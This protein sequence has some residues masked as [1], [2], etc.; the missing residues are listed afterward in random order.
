L[1]EYVQALRPSPIMASTR[2]LADRARKA[3]RLSELEFERLSASNDLL[4]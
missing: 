2:N 3:A 4:D 1:R